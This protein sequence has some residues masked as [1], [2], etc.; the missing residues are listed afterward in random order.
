MVEAVRPANNSA[1][2]DLAILGVG[3]VLTGSKTKVEMG[4]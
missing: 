1:W 3:S 4:S 2:V